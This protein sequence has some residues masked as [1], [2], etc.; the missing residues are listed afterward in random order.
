MLG[1]EPVCELAQGRVIG[2]RHVREAGP[3]FRRHL[4]AQRVET[5]QVEVVAEQHQVPRL[6]LRAQA[7]GGIG[8]DQH[9]DPE[10]GGEADREDG[11]VGVVPLVGMQAP[12][13]V[14]DRQVRP[15][16]QDVDLVRMAFDRMAGE[17]EKVFQ[18]DRP[19]DAFAEVHGETGPGHDGHARAFPAQAVPAVHGFL[20]RGDEIFRELIVEHGGIVSERGRWYAWAHFSFMGALQE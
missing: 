13:V 19:V 1:G 7:A 15:G 10:E 9:L 20:E 5:G 12:A 14:E 16:K 17:G 2:V 4:A 11:L 8:Q 3:P 18:R 6:V